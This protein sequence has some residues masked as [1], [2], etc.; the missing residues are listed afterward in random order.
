MSYVEVAVDAPV[1]PGRTFSYSIPQHMSLEPGQLVWVPFG[2]RILQGVV[3]NL[4][5][6]AQVEVTRDVLQPVEPSPVLSS[7]HLQL[8]LW[9]SRYYLCSL[10]AAVGLMLPPGFEARVRSRIT[11]ISSPD[12]C[13]SDFESLRPQSQEALEQLAGKPALNEAEFVKLLGRSG[14]RELARLID[15]GYVSRRVNL[16]RPQVPVLFGPGVNSRKGK[17]RGP[18]VQA[19][20]PSNGD[21]IQPRSLSRIFGQQG[22]WLWCRQS[23]GGQGNSGYGL[24]ARRYHAVC[25]FG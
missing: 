15:K 8:A 25:E 22:L 3:M 6:V 18:T 21:P 10:F 12:S 11:S 7:P 16:P 19:T 9:L 24:G 4:A 2:R 13:S 5:E 23:S 1:G 14:E 20:G 17:A